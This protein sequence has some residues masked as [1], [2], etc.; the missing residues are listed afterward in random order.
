MATKTTDRN[1][2][3]GPT[4]RATPQ[5][6]TRRGRSYPAV[7]VKV[8]GWKP[9]TNKPLVLVAQL[10]TRYE[11]VTGPTHRIR[12]A[13]DKAYRD[14]L[15]STL[16]AAAEHDADFLV[17][18]EYAWPI[19]LLRDGLR[20]LQKS[21]PEMG[22][23]ILPLEHIS[24]SELGKAFGSLPVSKEHA[25]IVRADIE[26]SVSTADRATAVVNMCAV[27]FKVNGVL[28]AFVQPKVRAAGLEEIASLGVRLAGGRN[29][30]IFAGPGVRIAATICFDIVARDEARDERP[31]D[32]VATMRPDILF[33]PEC[34]P[35]PLHEMY[36]RTVVDMFEE[37]GWARGQSVVV[38][39]NVARGSVLAGLTESYFG[40]SRCVGRLGKTSRPMHDVFMTAG[41]L[42]AHP[43]PVSLSAVEREGEYIESKPVTWAIAR[44]QESLVSLT[45]P[46]LGTGP[47]PDPSTGRTDTEISVSRWAGGWHRI[48]VSLDPGIALPTRS[49]GPQRLVDPS[50]VVPEEHIVRPS[51]VGAELVEHEFLGLLQTS[52]LP[53]WVFGDGGI[54]KTAIVANVL[55][56][57]VERH[58]LARVAW[59]D[60]AQLQSSE[61]D[62][63][64]ALLMQFGLTD[65]L[66]RPIGEKWKLIESELH[67]AA[68]IVVL[69]SFE[70]WDESDPKRRVPRELK[71]LHGWPTRVVV[72]S[73]FEPDD[74]EGRSVPVPRLDVASGRTILA[75]VQAPT[76]IPNQQAVESALGGHPLAFVW[77]AGLM[78]AAPPEAISFAASIQRGSN[79]KSV[80]EWCARQLTNTEKDVLSVLGELPAPVSEEDMSSILGATAGDIRVAVRRLRTLNLVEA[81]DGADVHARHPYVRQFWQERAR[82][83]VHAAIVDW[84]ERQLEV[85]G[86][87]RNWSGYPDL[88]R[89]WPNL[90]H[91]LAKLAIDDSDQSISRFLGMWRNADYFLWSKGRLRERLEYGRAAARVARATGTS[92]ELAHALY[93]SIAETLWHRDGDPGE[94]YALLNEARDLYRSLGDARGEA[95]VLYYL[96]RFARKQRCLQLA[97]Y[98]SIQAVRQANRTGD[99]QARGMAMNGLGNVYRDTRRWPRALAR[100]GRARKLL[101]KAN[102][103]ELVAVVDRNLGRCAY[104]IDDFGTALAKLEAAME[105]FQSLRLPVEEAEA[106]MYRGMALIRLGDLEEGATQLDLVRVY[107]T[108]IGAAARVRE[109]DE[110][111]RAGGFVDGLREPQQP[112]AA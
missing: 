58:W 89:R 34:N 3:K 1:N 85:Y 72:T 28:K 83:A 33:V 38:F 51:L 48:R 60:M 99:A 95:M 71:R 106:A 100:Y 110:A 52:P 42:V 19:S 87:D 29:R 112:G 64:D 82:G 91:V 79:A 26:S 25:R 5:R 63:A 73:R 53:V 109:L 44:Q 43:T 55:A 98:F 56:R 4:R 88:E 31:R 20:G 15:F 37:P 10:L 54:G 8:P 45:L 102:D 66:G 17:F 49:A 84:S 59:V 13:V 57:T 92:L 11:A 22:C 7:E 76:S 103:E 77:L 68:T 101:A 111:R 107:F 40:F 23:C 18:P 80:F 104:E 16:A 50:L 6:R 21:L 90:R 35:K 75:R 65:G 96:G 81:K 61:E 9:R 36:A 14:R 39:A 62:L 46:T 105:V 108:R 97:L 24:I 74:D 30:Y 32:A 41:G 78:R 12:V 86:G 2:A 70:R 27:V 47:S 93:E 69:D 67:A 94:C